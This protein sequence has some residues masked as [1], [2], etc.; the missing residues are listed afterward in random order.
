VKMLTDH[1]RGSIEVLPQ[2]GAALCI[3][4]KD[5]AHQ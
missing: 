2:K 5:D 3:R 1:L 4:F